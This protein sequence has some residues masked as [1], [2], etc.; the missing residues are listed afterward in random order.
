MLLHLSVH[1]AAARIRD[2]LDLRHRHPRLW[3][4]VQQLRIRA[5]VAAQITRA[6]AAAGLVVEQARWVDEQLAPCLDTL[7][8][9]PL[10]DKTAA[11]VIAA[12]PAGAEARRLA[13]ARDQ[14]LRTT[15]SNEHGLKTLVVRARAGDVIYFHAM[16]DRLA[17]ILAL[18]GQPGSADQLRALAATRILS[19]PAHA[20]ELLVKYATGTHTG[21]STAPPADPTP[22]TDPTGDPTGDPATGE[23]MAGELMADPLPTVEAAGPVTGP[24]T[25]PVAGPV[26]GRDRDVVRPQEMHPTD[27]DSDDDD[28]R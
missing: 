8:W 6:T 9:G 23:L 26:A 19:Q 13:A 4:A 12:D 16:A 18:E 15:R 2:A 7:G 24:V 27:D 5:G 17:Q 25:G 28:G 11:L 21:T 1:S 10:L 14:F 20:L 22:T 3:V